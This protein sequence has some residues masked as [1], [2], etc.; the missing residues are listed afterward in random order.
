MKRIII[1]L[2]VKM[3]SSSFIKLLLCS[4]LTSRQA[5]FLLQQQKERETHTHGCHLNTCKTPF[6]TTERR[7]RERE[8]ERKGSLQA[9]LLHSRCD[10]SV[11]SG[12]LLK[13][14]P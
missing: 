13:C 9:L 14:L 6:A 7:E 2:H 3:I 12:N 8:R 11:S 10:P 5:I 4:I 1:S